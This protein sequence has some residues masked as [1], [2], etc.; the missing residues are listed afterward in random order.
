MGHSAKANKSVTSSVSKMSIEKAKNETSWKLFWF[1][2]G[3]FWKKIQGDT[4]NMNCFWLKDFCVRI[5]VSTFLEWKVVSV[6]EWS[7]N[8]K[9]NITFE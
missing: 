9:K 5:K 1:K 3:F 8:F 4:K 2:M 6:F 7:Y